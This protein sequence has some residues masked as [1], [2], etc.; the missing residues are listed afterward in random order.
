[1]AKRRKSK[2]EAEG[3]S[4]VRRVDPYTRLGFAVVYDCLRSIKRARSYREYMAE[5]LWLFGRDGQ[6]FL[7]ALNLGVSPGEAV[8]AFAREVRRSRDA[9]RA[10]YLARQL[11]SRLAGKP[12][13]ARQPD[14]FD[15]LE[16]MKNE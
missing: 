16:V 4:E 13:M 1:M 15:D 12:G 8:L 5:V 2:A 9:N 3:R 14:L 7:D 6:L 10:A 11:R